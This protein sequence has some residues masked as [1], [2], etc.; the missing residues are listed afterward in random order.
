MVQNQIDP[1]V[2]FCPSCGAKNGIAIET[3][4]QCGQQLPG[5]CENAMQTGAGSSAQQ[6]G[7]VAFADLKKFARQ[8]PVIA[9]VVSALVVIVLIWGASYVSYAR[10]VERTT[11]CSFFEIVGDSIQDSLTGMFTPGLSVKDVKNNR[12]YVRN[13]EGLSGAEADEAVK[14]MNDLIRGKY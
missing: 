11:N 8:N 13:E 6:K 3:C 12:E 4:W 14:T 5:S 9:I 7:S 2:K 1:E 10:M